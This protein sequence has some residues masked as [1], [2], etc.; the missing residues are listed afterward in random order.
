MSIPSGTT[1]SLNV[2]EGKTFSV[3]KFVADS[4]V[5]ILKSGGGVLELGPTKARIVDVDSGG[6]RAL[7]MFIM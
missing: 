5:T 7:R 3:Q 4:S 2:A 1:V 6:A